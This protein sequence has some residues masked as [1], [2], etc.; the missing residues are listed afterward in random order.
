M[1]VFLVSCFVNYQPGA[2]ENTKVYFVA[3]LPH[4]CVS[5]SIFFVKLWQSD[6]NTFPIS[7]PVF[8]SM[9]ISSI[10]CIFKALNY[11]MEMY[12]PDERDLGI[13]MMN[14]TR[15]YDSFLC[16]AVHNNPIMSFSGRQVNMGYIGWIISHGLDF[17]KRV[18]ESK[19]FIFYREDIERFKAINYS[20][21]IA[22]DDDQDVNL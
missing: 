1:F 14:S 22:Q 20:Y 12:S 6:T 8:I 16:S 10:I 9:L 18:N 5:V 19:D 4:A 21:V 2:M 7:I 3:W 17:A 11:P 15:I 13:W